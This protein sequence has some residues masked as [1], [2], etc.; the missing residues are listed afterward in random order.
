[1]PQ[2][3]TSQELTSTGNTFTTGYSSGTVCPRTG[4]Y[5]A[6]N[7]YMNAILVVVAGAKFPNFID[8]KKCT[9]YALATSTTSTTSDGGFESAK[10]AAG[11]V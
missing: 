6:E 8:G 2:Q 9:W 4:S 11:T 7:K 10:V 1:M 5:K 3:V